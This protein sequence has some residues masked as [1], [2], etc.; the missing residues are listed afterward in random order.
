MSGS[1][2]PVQPRLTVTTETHNG[3]RHEVRAALRQVEEPGGLTSYDCGRS[4]LNTPDI[5]TIPRL[6]P[7]LASPERFHVTAIGAG[8]VVD[9]ALIYFVSISPAVG[10]GSRDGPRV[11]QELNE[12]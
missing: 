2:L 7:E 3:F 9:S 11:L 12:G 6:W 5:D 10:F 8:K 1:G 4:S